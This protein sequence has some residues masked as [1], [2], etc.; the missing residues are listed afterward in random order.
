MRARN[1][2]RLPATTSAGPQL[3]AP[4]PNASRVHH[5]LIMII[6]VGGIVRRIQTIPPLPPCLI[7][8]IIQLSFYT[9]EY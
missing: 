6:A 7:I 5:L 1:Y 3:P 8:I 4:A 9:K 2:Q